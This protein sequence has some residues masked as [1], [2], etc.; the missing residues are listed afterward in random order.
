MKV[1]TRHCV[2]KSI[3][4]TLSTCMPRSAP[5]ERTFLRPWRCP[6]VATYQS[7]HVIVSPD[8]GHASHAEVFFECCREA[9]GVVGFE[10]A[11]DLHLSDRGIGD[12]EMPAVVAIELADRFR[13]RLAVKRDG[14]HRP[15]QLTRHIASRVL[16]D[17]EGAGA[18]GDTFIAARPGCRVGQ[19]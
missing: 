15:G 7:N 6:W 10:A 9:F 13:Q 12:G 19:N 14:A 5:G 4:T 18:C 11:A 8:R 3:R 2:R 17:D 16:A 1:H